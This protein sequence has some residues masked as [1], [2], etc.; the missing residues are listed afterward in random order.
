MHI[1]FVKL[2]SLI[3]LLPT[4]IK[5]EEG[6]VG[7]FLWASSFNQPLADWDVSKCDGH[8]QYV[9]WSKFD[10]NRFCRLDVSV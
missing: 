3:N 8:A 5:C 1:C 7:T 4:G 2:L 10:I 6:H 9:P